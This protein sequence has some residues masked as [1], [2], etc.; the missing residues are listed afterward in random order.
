MRAVAARAPAAELA[1]E[2]LI[3]GCDG[4]IMGPALGEDDLAAVCAALAVHVPEHRLEE[5]AG[6]MRE[7]AAWVDPVTADADRSV[8]ID[9][10][11][12]ALTS[13]ETRRSRTRRASSSCARPP[14][15]PPVRR[16]TRSPR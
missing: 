11:R 9:A 3:A 12:R 1:V 14:T 15:S 16:S 8:G 13:T 2:A 4:L 5:A 6:R 10:A 7:L